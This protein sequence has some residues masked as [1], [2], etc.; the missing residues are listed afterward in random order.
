M[1]GIGERLREAREKK[2]LTIDQVQKKTHIH[3]TV[4]T[5]LEEG[6]CDEVLPPAYV[7]SFLKSYCSYLGLDSKDILNKYSSLHPEL[8]SANIKIGNFEIK[9]SSVDLSALMRIVKTGIIIIAALFLIAFLGNKAIGSFKKHRGTKR[10][11][12]DARLKQVNQP[13]ALPQKKSY[14]KVAAAPKEV[15]PEK[16]SFTLVVKLKQNVY[17]RVKKDGELLFERVLRKGASESFKAEQKIELYVA[18]AEA[19]EL[20]VEGKSLGSPGKGVIK[21]LEITKKGFRIR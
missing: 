17:V 12:S 9:N 20:I 13:K 5:A 18:K 7:K 16:A 15:M 3:S 11:L 21:N 6:K 1:A 19:I 14:E 8:Q 2:S 10:G 4:L